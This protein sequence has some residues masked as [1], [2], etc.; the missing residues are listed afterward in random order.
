MDIVNS[1]ARTNEPWIPR[2]VARSASLGLIA[3]VFSI[4]CGN[5]NFPPP[6]DKDHPHKPPHDAGAVDATP[7]A[8]VDASDA[9]NHS[10]VVDAAE[11][12]DAADAGSDAEAIPDCVPPCIRAALSPCLP[13]LDSC[14]SEREPPDAA[15]PQDYTDKICAP[16]EGFS[17]SLAST[18]HSIVQTITR[19]GTLCYRDSLTWGLGAVP[20]HLWFDATGTQVAIGISTQE[21]STGADYNVWCT[22]GIPTPNDVMYTLPSSCVLPTNRCQA[23]SP[24]DC[25]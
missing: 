15:W 13:I 21:N 6:P 18:Y 12:I 7:E 8:S 22:S 2:R 17:Y 20:T 9:A 4:A 25:P 14:L 3:S 10:D 1:S 16:A 11:P 23:T 19:N 5:R 24:G